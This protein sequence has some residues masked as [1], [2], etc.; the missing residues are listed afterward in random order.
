MFYTVLST[1]GGVGKTTIAQQLIAPYIH[2]KNHYKAEIIEL[3]NNNN[4]NVLN[5]A[6][7][8]ETK[9][10]KLCKTENI[11]LEKFME[12]IAENKDV[13][14]DV[15]GGDDTKT[16]LKALKEL[17]LENE[18]TFIIPVHFNTTL[19]SVKLVIEKVKQLK[20]SMRI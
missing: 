16:V 6:Q 4:S 10:L 7:T 18:I 20:S 15:G 14:I 8:Q 3:D 19:V 11:L 2:N 9:S 13:C 12:V 5:E 1:K 17:R